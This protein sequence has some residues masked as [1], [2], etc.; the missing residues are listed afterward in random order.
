MIAH[1][2]RMAWNRRRTNLFLAG[3]LLLSFLV[4]TP[5]VAGWVLF[6]AEELKPLGFEYEGVWY[7]NLQARDLFGERMG[8]SREQWKKAGEEHRRNIELVERELRGLD[9]VEEVA[10]ASKRPASVHECVEWNQFRLYLGRG[11]GGPEAAAAQRAL[12]W[13]RGRRTRLDPSRHRPGVEPGVVRRCG[14][15]GQN[16]RGLTGN[17]CQSEGWVQSPKSH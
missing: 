8:M 4:L 7:S 17:R 6:A 3:E 12:V 13:S 16:H 9:Q 2:C 10:L 15:G 5:L 1:L 11:P 14:S